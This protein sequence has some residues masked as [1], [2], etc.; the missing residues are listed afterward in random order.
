VLGGREVSWALFV[1]SK[2]EEDGITA[3]DDDN[4][5]LSRDSSVSLLTLEKASSALLEGSF[6]KNFFTEK[7]GFVTVDFGSTQEK[8]SMKT[9]MKSKSCQQNLQ[10]FVILDFFLVH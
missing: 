4:K 7:Q 1:P 3:D 6:A 5:L 10:G 9:C 8:A 2:E